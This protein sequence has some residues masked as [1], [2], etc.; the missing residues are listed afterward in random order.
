MEGEYTVAEAAQ[1]SVGGSQKCEVTCCYSDL[2]K[3]WR[4]GRERLFL[5]ACRKILHERDQPGLKVVCLKE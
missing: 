5:A 1:I 3:L 4:E 2:M